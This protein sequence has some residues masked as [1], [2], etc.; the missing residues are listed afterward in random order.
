MPQA[1]DLLEKLAEILLYNFHREHILL[2]LKIKKLLR[3]NKSKNLTDW[4]FLKSKFA[5]GIN[6]KKCKAITRKKKSGKCSKISNTLKLRTP[7]IIAENNF[8]N[9]LKNRTLTFFLKSEFPKLRTQVIFGGKSMF[10]YARFTY[11]VQRHLEGSILLNWVNWHVTFF[12]ACRAQDYTFCLLI[13]R[14][15]LSDKIKGKRA[16]KAQTFLHEPDKVH[17]CYW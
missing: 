17:V 1:Q 11:T 12:F 5:K 6:S 7:K 14:Y 8:Q 13:V 10:V 4:K 9:I 3:K 15:M 2:K 16:L